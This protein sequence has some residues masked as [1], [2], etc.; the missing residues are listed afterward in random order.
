MMEYNG[1]KIKWIVLKVQ[2]DDIQ[3]SNDGV[4]DIQINNDG[5]TMVINSNE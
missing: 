3:I 2:V 4:E 5:V 1:Y